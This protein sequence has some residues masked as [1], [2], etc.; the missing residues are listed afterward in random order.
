[1]KTIPVA[2]FFHPG[3]YFLLIDVFHGLLNDFGIDG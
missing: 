1:M 2:N 3:S